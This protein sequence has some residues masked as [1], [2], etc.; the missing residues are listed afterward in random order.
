MTSTTVLT[1][2]FTQRDYMQLP[3]GFPAELIDGA[4]VREPAPTYWHQDV[5]VEIAT[6]LRALLGRGRVAV[7]P[8]DVL[9][10]DWNVFQPDVLVRR[11]EDAVIGPSAESTIPVLVVEVLARTTARR[12]RERK[13]AVYL[14]A[15][16]GEVWLADPDEGAVE[17]HTSAEVRRF[18]GGETAQS[19]VVEGFRL[20]WDELAAHRNRAT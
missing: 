19:R 17:V 1:E 2:K 10:D 4:F 6:R 9:L 18:R 12:D 13:T 11:P 7:S 20:S 14:R 3:E 15:G 5:V 8:I 16:V